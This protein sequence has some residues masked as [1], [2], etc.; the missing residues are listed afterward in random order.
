MEIKLMLSI[1][2]NRAKKILNNYINCSTRIVSKKK[3]ASPKPIQT[4]ALLVDPI[5]NII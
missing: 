2:Q 3:H 5:E 4:D 1:V